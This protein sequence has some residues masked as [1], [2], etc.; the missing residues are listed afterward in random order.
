MAWEQHSSHHQ[1]RTDATVLLQRAAKVQYLSRYRLSTALN[2]KKGPQYLQQKN[3]KWNEMAIIQTADHNK[4]GVS[5]PRTLPRNAR[6]MLD[7]DAYHKRQRSI[8]QVPHMGVLTFPDP[9]ECRIFETGVQ[10]R[11]IVRSMPSCVIY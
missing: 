11:G 7:Q 5:A 10:G 1:Y 4:R 2:N 3:E 8:N 9:H 6:S